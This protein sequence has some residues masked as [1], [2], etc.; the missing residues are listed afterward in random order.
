MLVKDVMTAAPVTT[1]AEASIHEAL[2]LLS[3]NGV[4][5]LPVIDRTGR[6]VGVVSEADLIRDS[7]PLDPRARITPVDSPG[8]SPPQ[9]VD[10]VMTTHAV[11]VHVDADLASAVELMTS[12]SVKALPVVD[13][14]DR[15]VGVVS[16]S[17]VVRILARADMTIE[18]EV[19]ALLVS[20]GHDD[21]LVEVHDGVVDVNG[22]E[23]VNERSLAD[24]AAHTV[25]G[26]IE[27]R[28]GSTP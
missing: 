10:E 22:P 19:D 18:H 4:T 26:V 1:R 3:H 14:R 23:S 12:T 6:L 13:S 11:T 21:W 20:L 16:R 8:I 15:V 7:V 25:A 28:V 17:D 27:V 24:L 9:H 2:M 5:S